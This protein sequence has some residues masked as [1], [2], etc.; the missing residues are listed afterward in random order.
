MTFPFQQ[1]QSTV[2]FLVPEGL[3][4]WRPRRSG[5]QLGIG[6]IINDRYRIEKP[7]QRDG[8]RSL[9]TVSLVQDSAVCDSRISKREETHSPFCMCGDP[10]LDEHIFQMEV[11]PW[12]LETRLI[13]R[14]LEISH[15][16]ILKIHDIFSVPSTT[17]IVSEYTSGPTLDCVDRMLTT[18]QVRMFGICL[19]KTVEFLH[20]Q[21]ISHVN[22]EPSNLKLV[23]DGPI[24]MSLGTSALRGDL[25]R[26]DL[27]WVDRQDFRRVLETLEKLA[28]EYVDEHEDDMLCRLLFALEDMIE[29][30]ELSAID[31]LEALGP[32]RFEFDE[33]ALPFGP[34]PL[35]ESRDKELP[36]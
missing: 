18:H 24:L 11:V 22:L 16:G 26:E 29:R 35:S 17:Y 10:E 1:I 28:A 7:V 3:A 23:N 31:I 36:F 8:N 34:A 19:A 25:S 5:D 33:R 4:G 14:L 32:A 2:K 12:K 13:R 21:G 27:E 20:R 9:N 6:S 30:N 15:P